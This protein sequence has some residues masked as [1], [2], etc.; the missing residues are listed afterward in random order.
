SRVTVKARPRTK[1]ARKRYAGT[2]YQTRI[3]TRTRYHWKARIKGV[4][5]ATVNRTQVP[6]VSSLRNRPRNNSTA[7]QMSR[8]T[9]TEPH[10]CHA[11]AITV[12]DRPAKDAYRPLV[13]FALKN[14]R[15]PEGIE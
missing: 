5:S 8:I 3:W 1:A 4:V 13:R 10:P 9:D 2:S 15:R 7:K 11:R 6:I 14:A 12:T